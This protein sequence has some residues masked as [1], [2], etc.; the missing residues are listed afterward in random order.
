MNTN[1]ETPEEYIKSLPEDRRF[2][3]SALREVILK[4]L[5][6]GF[7]EVISYGMVSYVVPHSLYPSGYH[8]NP[9]QPLPFISI[10]SQKNYIA[11]YHMGLYSNEKVLDWFK[12]EYPKHSSKKLDIG[13]SCIR[14]KNVK[15]IPYQLVG[16]LAA[17]INP[18]EWIRTYQNSL[19]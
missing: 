11:L 7:S 4:N 9:S 15:E 3:L 16:E 5:P 19:K 14:F 13:K 2:A 6:E 1:A 8:V 10:A 18:Q 17:K 12:T